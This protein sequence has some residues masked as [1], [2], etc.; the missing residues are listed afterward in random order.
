[1]GV[2]GRVGRCGLLIPHALLYPEDSAATDDVIHTTMTECIIRVS[3]R[4][5]PTRLTARSPALPLLLLSARRWLSLFAR[6]RALEWAIEVLRT[7][8]RAFT[9]VP[10]S[11]PC[12]LEQI[13]TSQGFTNSPASTP[14]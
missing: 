13:N 9:V 14:L 11:F 3:T 6:K 4:D 8:Y 12:R 2:E 5:Y 10:A 7:D 1:M